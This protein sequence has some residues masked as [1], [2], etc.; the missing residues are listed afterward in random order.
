MNARRYVCVRMVFAKTD[1]LYPAFCLGV[2]LCLLMASAIS[3]AGSAIGTPDWPMFR[4]NPSLTGI[5]GGALETPLSLLWTFKTEKPVKSSPAIAGGNVF[6]GSD[7]GRMYSIDL[8]TGKKRW[9]F[10]TE[11]TVESSPLVLADCAY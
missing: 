5:A 2:S 10:K 1:R 7:D 9:G 3:S 8:N 6:V 11:G 4:A